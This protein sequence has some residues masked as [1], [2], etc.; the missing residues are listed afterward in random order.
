MLDPVKLIVYFRT[1]PLESALRAIRT[2]EAARVR[3]A[4]KLRRRLPSSLLYLVA[5]RAAYLE[6]VGVDRAQAT[7]ELA[8]E[9]RIRLEEHLRRVQSLLNFVVF[10]VATLYL[11][12]AM[13]GVLSLISPV[14]TTM[15]LGFIAASAVMLL[16]VEPYLRPIRRWNYYVAAAASAPAVLSIAHPA[17]AVLAAAVGAAY[18]YWYLSAAREAREELDLVASGR[19][20]TGET[21][22]AKEMAEV[23]RAV[24]ES[25][26]FD[27]QAT[28]EFL[29]RIWLAY[30]DSVRRS[31]L[32]RALV[33][34]ATFAIFAGSMYVL[35][36]LFAPFAKTPV[37][38]VLPLKIGQLDP[39]PAVYVAALSAMVIAGRLTDSYAA[40][41]AYSP[42]VLALL[43]F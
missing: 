29:M 39:R 28:A 41:P 8:E 10:A 40:T 30:L 12:A 25:G 13:G 2:R 24:R 20:R 33:V 17:F 22:L 23:V 16:L 18:A 5:E 14:G 42:L 35:A 3:A 4:L 36:S 9:L 11:S 26:A 37:P 15:M 21:D 38:P 1:A 43:F 32:V 19:V 7:K 34:V 27:L 6:A 31:A